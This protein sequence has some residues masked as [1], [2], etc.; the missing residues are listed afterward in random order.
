MPIEL[1]LELN[2]LESSRFGIV[3]ARITDPAASLAAIDEAAR[4]V[5]VQMAMVRL[6]A[7]DLA[8]VHAFEA[9]GYRLMDTLV[10]YGRTLGVEL[11]APVPVPGVT[12]RPATVADAPAVAAVARAGFGDYLGHYHADPRLD[13]A[14]ADEAYV[15]WAQTSTQRASPAAPV[16]VAETADGIGGFLTLREID[17][18]AMEIVLNAVRPEL[19]GQG[20]YGLLVSEALALAAGRCA[21]R[22]ITSTQLN[23]YA[24]QKVWTRLGFRHERSF[25]T[26]HKWW[27]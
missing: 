16:L 1:P 6:P 22:M 4:A 26:F 25:Y 21:A 23:N 8:R 10:Y 5:G 12:C 9:A 20:I 17:P 14:A 2:A 27:D 18:T 24:P 19:G 7:D 3:A 15:D 13:P 11:P